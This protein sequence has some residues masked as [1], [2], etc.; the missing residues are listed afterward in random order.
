MG[1]LVTHKMMSTRKMSAILRSVRAFLTAM[2]FLRAF[3]DQMVQFVKLQKYQGWDKKLPIP[4]E[5]QEQVRELNGLMEKWKG[6]TLL[7]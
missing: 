3:T 5:L 2:P 7:G 6:R 4:S 1:K